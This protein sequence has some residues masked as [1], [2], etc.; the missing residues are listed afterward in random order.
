MLADGWTWTGPTVV[1]GGDAQ[2]VCHIDPE[3]AAPR[4]EHGFALVAHNERYGHRLLL[5]DHPNT[6]GLELVLLHG[7]RLRSLQD[8]SSGGSHLD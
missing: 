5:R 8:S 1:D 3:S 2:V 4:R 7:A 6:D